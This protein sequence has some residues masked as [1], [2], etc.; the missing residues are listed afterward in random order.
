M[1]DLPYRRIWGESAFVLAC[2]GASN[3]ALFLGSTLVI[4]RFQ[5]MAAETDRYFLAASLLAVGALLSSQGVPLAALKLLAAARG[6][7]RG[8]EES[9][10]L[11]ASSLRLVLLY[12]SIAS[13]SLW[14]FL[15]LAPVHRW[16]DGESLGLSLCVLLHAPAKWVAAVLQGLGRIRLGALYDVLLDAGRL[17]ALGAALGAGG[18][19]EAVIG[20]WVVAGALHLAGGVILLASVLPRMGIAAGSPLF[21]L[22][23]AREGVPEASPARLAALSLS[24]FLPFAGLFAITQLITLLLGAAGAPG[25]A[26]RWA[27]GMQVAS[28][29]L[30]LASPLGTVLLPH[31][32]LAAA[33]GAGRHDVFAGAAPL[34]LRA[35]LALTG[36]AALLIAFADPLIR[37]LF[38]PA[39]AP[40][41]P[42]CRAL[43][44]LYLVESFK[45]LLDPP[46]VAQGRWKALAWVEASRVGMVI[47]GA[48][49][50]VAH[51][52]IAG[53][54][55]GLGAAVALSAAGRLY[56]LHPAGVPGR[57]HAH[58]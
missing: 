31:L 41:A 55:A 53:A 50:A 27:L 47:A 16:T 15:S 54:V 52:S 11:M 17:A 10:L 23:A 8:T 32:S 3:A 36:A 51:W 34:L 29:L 45:H 35:G 37:F 42:V 26:S 28:I 7:N 43:C 18:G 13:F 22:R 1:A 5:G 24:L 12:S 39:A 9:P 56:L 44:V 2:I 49:W 46:L 19:V 38:S 21:A 48:W 58:V 57:T 30:V 40:A 4:R 25:D 14:A 6:R 33:S 20:G